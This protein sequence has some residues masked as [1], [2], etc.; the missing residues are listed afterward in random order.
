MR[1]TVDEANDDD[2]DD[3]WDDYGGEEGDGDAGVF[4]A[5]GGFNVS[6]H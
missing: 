4:V 5:G 3:D 1:A 2:D 6:G